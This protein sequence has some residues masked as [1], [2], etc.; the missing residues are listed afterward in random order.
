MQFPALGKEANKNPHERIRSARR[1]GIPV[2]APSIE[3]NNPIS[4]KGDG[5]TVPSLRPCLPL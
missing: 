2:T 3:S 4:F 5:V 1:I